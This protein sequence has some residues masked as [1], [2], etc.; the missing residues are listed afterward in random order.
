MATRSKE[1]N[2]GVYPSGVLCG[3][4]NVPLVV[5][6]GVAGHLDLPNPDA[7]RMAARAILGALIQA[8]DAICPS[9]Q[10][11]LPPR[12][13]DYGGP[14]SEIRVISS[15]AAGADQIFASEGLV[16]GC[17]L[18]AVLPFDRA[19]FAADIGRN[20]HPAPA[21]LTVAWY[22][23]LLDMADRVLEL[24]GSPAETD[25]AYPRAASLLLKN[26]DILMVAISRKAGTGRGGTRW[27][28][29]EAARARVPVI[30]V[31]VE[32]PAQSEI[33]WAGLPDGRA[34]VTVETLRD[35]FGTLFLPPP[36]CHASPNSGEF[37]QSFL[38]HLS[39]EYNKVMMWGKRWPESELAPGAHDLLS[40]KLAPFAVWSDHRSSGYSE[41]TRGGAIFTALLG[42]MAVFFALLGLFGP[43]AGFVGKVLELLPVLAVAT[44]LVRRSRRHRWRD[45]WLNYRQLERSLNYA[46][47]M[48]LQGR[49]MRFS[50]P[51]HVAEFHREAW[52]VAW[53]LDVV[54][55]NAGFPDAVMDGAYRERVRGL[56]S[57]LVDE[58]AAFFGEE[59]N[60]HEETDRWLETWHERC[61]WGAMVATLV[62]LLC[63]G[64]KFWF[65]WETAYG[66]VHAPM[67]FCA[68]GLPAL[69][70]AFY[71]IRQHGEYGQQQGRYLG[72]AAAMR[73]HGR[74]LA[75]SATVAS[76]EA[77]AA[78]TAEVVETLLQEMYHW[79][80]MLQPKQVE[81][82]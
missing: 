4:P 55:R 69:A 38:F 75:E 25:A 63:W 24:D 16:A 34:P 18:H 81:H 29:E 70:A 66:Y 52:W 76:G 68:A 21:D 26:S 72:M 65:G 35:I 43:E 10:A 42:A 11:A 12:K 56:L 8:V 22:W 14:V 78:R 50:P 27:L 5:R 61:L 36:N 73:E 62:Y 30:C 1:P 23:H 20:C 6:V 7:V 64:V 67:T 58:Q 9:F 31:W 74:K 82:H 32:D 3:A 28:T 53:Y 49:P 80:G 41:M 17:R 79:R 19:T 2:T 40:S 77:L 44:W 46:A 37:E 59:R 57:G 47:Y 45:R 33:Q 60:E 13:P 71:A 54:L 51:A 15:L 39:P 48:T